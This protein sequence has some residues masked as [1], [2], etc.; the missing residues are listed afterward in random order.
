VRPTDQRVWRER[1]SLQHLPSS[2][3]FQ[4]KYGDTG[5]NLSL[6]LSS[7]GLSDSQGQK[8]Y[9]VGLQQF[10]LLKEEIQV[11]FSVFDPCKHE[12]LLGY[13]CAPLRHGAAATKQQ[14]WPLT[15]LLQGI[16]TGLAFFLLSRE[17]A[18]TQTTEGTEAAPGCHAAAC[19][20]LFG[21]T[22]FS[23]V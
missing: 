7:M 23:L 6:L 9:V 20:R 11:L 3:A 19:K 5:T 10:H 16:Q 2:G 12:Q 17:P 8:V 22:D 4:G 1:A 18:N 15:E 14:D 13:P 21:K